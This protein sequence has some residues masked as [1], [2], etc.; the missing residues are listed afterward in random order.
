MNRTPE[1]AWM[2][3]ALDEPVIGIDGK[4]PGGPKQHKLGYVRIPGVIDLSYSK[5]Q[6]LH[7]CARLFKL[8]E[9]N[10]LRQRS[11]SVDT[12]YGHAF[13]AG[14]QSFL[15][16]GDRELAF[17]EL[18]MMWDVDVSDVKPKARKSLGM[19]VAKLEQFIDFIYPLHFEGKWKCAHLM[20]GRPAVELHYYIKIGDHYS[21]QGHIDLVLESVETGELCVLEIKTGGG[22]THEAK[23]K[24]SDQTTGYNVVLDGVAVRE[25]VRNKYQVIYLYCDTTG[26]EMDSGDA[27]YGFTLFHFPKS[28]R[29]KVDYINTLLLD[30]KQ[31]QMYTEAG[32]WPK[33]GNHCH[34]FYKTCEFYGVCDLDSMLNAEHSGD[35]AYESLTLD[36]VDYVFELEDLLDIQRPVEEFNYMENHLGD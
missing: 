30:I 16:Y 18:L 17:C 19:C 21:Q 6:T 1:P 31:I 4:T 13:A 8:R 28:P 7:G 32:F 33:N 34:S 12:A 2:A 24:N 9:L 11:S 5:R 27:G 36:E 23:W 15:A 22:E 26:F 35:N 29:A 10:D 3:A 25:E 20:N 14:V